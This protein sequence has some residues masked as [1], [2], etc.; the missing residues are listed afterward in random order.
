MRISLS[1]IIPWI[2]EENGQLKGGFVS[3]AGILNL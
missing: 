1:K 3:I 2:H